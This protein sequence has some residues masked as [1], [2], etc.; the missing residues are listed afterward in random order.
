II[1]GTLVYASVGNGLD[2]L[3]TA[4]GAPSLGIIFK[5]EILGPIVGLG[6]LSLLPVGYK[7]WKARRGSASQPPEGRA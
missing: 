1:P 5:P 3:V 6:I 2:A 7:K 4:G